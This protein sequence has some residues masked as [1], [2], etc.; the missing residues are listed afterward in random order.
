MT[1][2]PPLDPAL[3]GEVYIARRDKRLDDPFVRAATFDLGVALDDDAMWANYRYFLEAVVPVAE[4]AGVRIALHP[5][6]PPV[7]SLAGVARLFR[8]VDALVRATEIVPSA[9]SAI[10]LCLGTV[11]EMGGEPAVLDA[12]ERLGAAGRIAYVHLRDV[13]GTV[14]TFEECFLGEGNYDPLTVLRAL[15]RVGFDGFLLDDHVPRVVG[16]SDYMHRGRAHAIGYV[17]GLL[18][19]LDA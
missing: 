10:E 6:D 19:A 8:S 1:T 14:P 5:D 15:R 11:S 4:E 18:H 12:I 2:K 16:D 13:K 9:A 7:P 17:Q 3:A